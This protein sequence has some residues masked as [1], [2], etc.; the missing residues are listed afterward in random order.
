MQ[1]EEFDV[2][3]EDNL[4]L[5]RRQFERLYTNWKNAE[6][7][8]SVCYRCGK[9]VHCIAECPEAI[10][11]K[12]E[13]E[14]R[15]RTD[16]KHRLRDDYKGKNKSERRPRKSGGHKKKT[17]RVMVAGVSNIDSSSCYSSLSSSGEEEV[18]RHKGKRS[19]KNI[20]G[21]CFASQGFCGMAR[22]S[23]SKKSQKDDSDSESEDELNNDP[24]FLVAEN[25]RLNEL[26]DNHDVVLRKTNKVKREYMSLL[27]EAKE[28]VIELV[29]AC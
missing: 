10:E 20:N 13:H 25:A 4:S 27:G 29:Y 6:R 5:L 11:I 28:K 17:E 26:L 21:M 24:A 8:S 3:G 9:H 7:S 22:S 12:S 19:S 14:H 1:D 18:D 23:E 16:H 2:L 15:P